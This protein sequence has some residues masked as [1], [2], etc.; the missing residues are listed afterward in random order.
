L[1]AENYAFALEFRGGPVI[2]HLPLREVTA[3]MEHLC[4]DLVVKTAFTAYVSVYR[5]MRFTQLSLL[6]HASPSTSF[7]AS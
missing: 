2:L 4:V 1:A 3:W 6:S 5:D 7:L